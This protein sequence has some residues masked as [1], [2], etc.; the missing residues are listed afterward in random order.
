MG[1][2]GAG[3]GGV[4]P[5]RTAPRA[6]PILA[7]AFVIAA[8]ASP[9]ST[10]GPTIDRV[11]VVVEGQSARD[12]AGQVATLWDLFVVAAIGAVRAHGPDA[13]GVT[14]DADAIRGAQAVVVEQLVVLREAARIGR[15]AVPPDLVDEARDALAERAGGHD[16]LRRFLRERAVAME[17]VEA[18]LRREMVA[19]R[20]ARDSVR[21]AVS[22]DPAALRELFDR[23]DHAFAGRS[24]EE[25]AEEFEASVRVR[26]LA[27]LRRLWLVDLR[28]RCRLRVFDVSADIA[29]AT[30]AQP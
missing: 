13:A 26:R 5:R 14:V 27:E 20:F 7:A 10:A 15:D 11:A 23:G 8:S 22:E 4:D 30:G 19:A 1:V 28:G 12:R 24:W 6:R 16:A 18:A 29:P 3:R 21:P 17:F 2:P 9:S 25:V